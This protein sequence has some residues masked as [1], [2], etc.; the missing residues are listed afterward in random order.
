M[1]TALEIGLVA[2]ILT[3]Q[4]GPAHAAVTV[5]TVGAY[6]AFTVTY[7]NTRIPIRKVS[8]PA[9]P[10]STA[11]Q[12]SQTAQPSPPPDAPPDQQPL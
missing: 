11:S 8:Q 10:A 5:A 1:P 12:H 6:T 9:Q 3:T 7:S 4:F 2:G